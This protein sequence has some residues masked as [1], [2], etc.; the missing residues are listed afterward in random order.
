MSDYK[1]VEFPDGKG[2]TRHGSERFYKL[3][4]EMAE[5]HDKKSHDYA[6]DNDPFGNYHFAGLIAN[7]FSY[8]FHDAGFAGRLA[9]KIF[10]ISVLE[11]GGKTPKNES[12]ADTELDIAVIAVLWMADRQE[13]RMKEANPLSME[14]FDL[15]KRM[16]S[17]QQTNIV[18]Y[19][20]DLQSERNYAT[21]EPNPVQSVPYTGAINQIHD[22]LMEM[23]GTP[24]KEAPVTQCEAQILHLLQRIAIMINEY[25]KLPRAH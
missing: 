14:L 8:S 2:F 9:E 7:M 25:L 21:Q 4:A 16:N 18:R 1:T 23:T 20:Q 19:I 11:G 24:A 6:K 5:L 3:L 22:K 15:I 13:R 17:E 12:I 10:R